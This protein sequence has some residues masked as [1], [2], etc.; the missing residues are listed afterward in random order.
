MALSVPTVG[1]DAVF[2]ADVSGIVSDE[3]GHPLV[4]AHVRWQGRGDESMVTTDAW[5]QFTLTMDGPPDYEDMYFIGIAMKGYFNL[6]GGV[7][8]GQGYQIPLTQVPLEDNTNY[9]WV[10]PQPV[11]E[12][13]PFAEGLGCGACHNDYYEAWKDSRHAE[14]TTSP[15]VLDLY[16]GSGGEGT[17]ETQGPGY[18][19]DF[20]DQAGPCANCH[21]AT[22]ALD[23]PNETRLDQ[24]EGV[25]TNGVYCETC[26]KVRDLGVP[27]ETP[28][29]GAF[30]YWRPQNGVLMA[31]GP[32]DDASDEMHMGPMS[33]LPEMSQA[34]FCSGCHE[35]N[36]EHG[37]PIMET[38]TEWVESPFPELDI[39]CQD[40][41]MR[42]LNHEESPRPLAPANWD[43][44]DPLCLLRNPVEA[45]QSPGDTCDRMGAVP[46]DESTINPHGFVG[47]SEDFL[48]AA[49]VI[50]MDSVQWG[51]ITQLEV[52]VENVYAGHRFPTGM[53]FRNAVLVVTAEDSSGEA[54]SFI[55]GETLPDWVGSQADGTD[56]VGLPGRGFAKIVSDG[57]TDNVSFWNA[58]EIV[59]DTRIP[60]GAKDVSYYRFATS[61][62]GTV[63]FTATLLYRRFMPE[64][65]EDKGWDTGEIVIGARTLDVDV[66]PAADAVEG[67]EGCNVASSNT[68]AS[69]TLLM[70]FMGLVLIG[71]GLRSRRRALAAAS[72][73]AGVL[74][75]STLA[76]C[77]ESSTT[78]AEVVSQE[79]ESYVETLETQL[80]EAGATCDGDLQ[81]ESGS[82][83]Q[84]CMGTY[85]C[86]PTTCETHQDC[87]ISAS[88]QMSCCSSGACVA[89]PGS[90]G[91][92]N[93][94]EGENCSVGG[95]TDCAD[96]LTCVN[97]CT[98]SAFCAQPCEASGE[99]DGP[100]HE[101]SGLPTEYCA[102]SG[103]ITSHCFEDEEVTE[104]C[105]INSDCEHH[106]SD[107][108]CDW[109]MARSGQDYTLM[110]RA[111][112]WGPNDRGH[113]CV[114]QGEPSH[115]QCAVGLCWG[116][117][118]FNDL[119][120]GICR[121][122]EGDADCLCADGESNCTDQI[123]I[124]YPYRLS[125]TDTELVTT[126]PL[127]FD[128][129]RCDSDTDCPDD[130]YCATWDQW[131]DLQTVC[132]PREYSGNA[133][134]IACPNGNS[135]CASRYCVEGECAA[136]GHLG[137]ACEGDGDCLNDCIDDRCTGPCDSDE[138]CADN[139]DGTFT[140]CSDVAIPY[141]PTAEAA[142]KPISVCA[143]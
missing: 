49:T 75:L 138:Y 2:A 21:A 8:P 79:S 10:P 111:T 38:Y 97:A 84:G 122:D 85:F 96:G 56:L 1:A 114:T 22:A 130:R 57:E 39:Q 40:C 123:C 89:V 65:A 140:S 120:A 76:G 137:D 104:A 102:R 83:L 129:A 63:T 98:T 88:G 72:L 135:D 18:L 69:T 71:I 66:V 50:E 4:G 31:F 6:G 101:E 13:S 82:C 36:N 32:L 27:H 47:S 48:V 103:A 73:V 67:D 7:A 106:G 132:L 92:G 33:Y 20:P 110:C 127:C 14:A 91:E 125:A 61:T 16:T 26:H 42:P 124:N 121:P 37:V 143:E 64:L 108:I 139:S 90:C 134:G 12:F 100:D 59:S 117:G 93:V 17:V 95:N 15:Y 44:G 41:H 9:Q 113:S 24:V 52:S 142:T 141:G 109:S 107:A 118:A 46:R 133:N 11:S 77:S 81:C 119:C 60:G 94:A 78:P 126:V 128:G 116:G 55:G 70:F 136:L 54:I 112:P 28:A 105:E 131:E 34:R 29:T 35:W 23:A 87:P 43:E 25:H 115:A 30:Q 74:T 53:P 45:R 86:A 80:L 99:C 5:G 62:E 68:S 3:A 19:V 51:G 58:T